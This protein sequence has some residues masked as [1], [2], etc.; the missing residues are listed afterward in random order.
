MKWEQMSTDGYLV[1]LRQWMHNGNAWRITVSFV[2]EGYHIHKDGG[3]QY[4]M[5][6]SLANAKK[7][8]HIT[9]LQLA[10]AVITALHHFLDL[11]H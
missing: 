4:E 5:K 9:H 2:R 7:E 6:Y 1:S 3:L 11:L 8:M 10:N